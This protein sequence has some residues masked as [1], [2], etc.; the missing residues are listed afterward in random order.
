M[1]RVQIIYK[2]GAIILPVN[3]VPATSHLLPRVIKT[4]CQTTN[5]TSCNR[6]SCWYCNIFF[7]FS[8]RMQQILTVWTAVWHTGGSG[9]LRSRTKSGAVDVGVQGLY[10]I[11]GL[12]F[13]V[14]VLIVTVCLKSLSS[15]L[16][17]PF[18]FILRILEEMV[19]S[20]W[21]SKTCHVVCK[22]YIYQHR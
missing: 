11:T 4:L 13:R 18:V 6:T 2:S 1:W 12:L 8:S 19:Y 20:W 21:R 14:H 22:Q 9:E 17:V 15:T 3:A 10:H 16:H 7:L 5:K